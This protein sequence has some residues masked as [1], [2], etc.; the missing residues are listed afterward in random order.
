MEDKQAKIKTKEELIAA[1]LEYNPKADTA[2]IGKAYD[3]ADEALKGRLRLSG[4]PYFE[5]C[6]GTAEIM[7]NMK[8][9][10]TAIAAS[11]LHHL[12]S[13]GR[14]SNDKIRQ[15][16]GEEM[17]NLL[18]DI[19]KITDIGA[20]KK[21]ER[22]ENLRKIILATT[23]D[24]RVIL[25]KLA[26][27]LSN[28]RTLKYLPPDKQVII[29]QETMYI[30]AQIAHKLG[31][32]LIKTELQ[33]LAF[34][35]LQ[36]E[37]FNKIK[38]SIQ[39]KKLEREEEVSSAMKRII[40]ELGRYGIKAVVK[41]R[42]KSFYSI[43]NKM[44]AK[45]KTMD[46]I[47][48]LL[49]VRIIVE[50]I[51]VCY[52]VLG[53]VHKIYTPLPGE[54]DDYIANPKSN[55]YQSLHTVVMTKEGR[56][57]EVQIRTKK[58]DIDAE[59]GIAAHWRYKGVERD[60][61]FEK[62]IGWLREILEWTRDSRDADEFLDTLKVDLFKDEICVFTPKGDPITLPEG[63]TPIDF[64]YLVHT[65]IGERCS[66]AKVNSKLVGLDTKLQSGDVVEIIT[67]N[68]AKP[69]RNWLK[70]CKTN[71]ARAKIRHAL[72]ITADPKKDEEE[73]KQI[74]EQELV[75]MIDYDVKNLKVSKCCTIAIGDDITGI[76]TKDGKLSVHSSRC[77]NV[78]SLPQDRWVKLD[79][80]KK[81]EQ[82]E[83]LVVYIED[84]P[85]LL[86][87][88]LNMIA[89]Q[90][91]TLESVNTKARKTDT[92]CLFNIKV[93]NPERYKDF[94]EKLKKV[95]GVKAVE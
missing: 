54:F 6:L 85:G 17:L 30:Y 82:E 8:A 31:I 44:T 59:E 18:Q 93:N 19:S 13:E 45:N 29:A 48:D 32:N 22:A 83:H 26:D 24:T 69:S 43:Y 27:R 90:G 4:R 88:I 77:I 21:A 12:I 87:S 94:T 55:G 67:S 78:S 57:I 72:G 56:Q 15:E 1:V 20:D 80:I 73:L 11:L 89:R 52:T 79:W 7:V 38:R 37:E 3:F 25:I 76:K 95:E 51:E 14:A 68:S 5:H 40:G 84:R 53:I 16:F 39:E 81:K 35:Y 75:S 42:A 9:G 70:F 50:N 64:A 47:Y 10:S 66:K 61:L 60:A 91:I 49:A 36:P 46:E 58:M 71:A 23:K 41:G 2:L 33:D 92:Q 34:K 74:S 28:M 62:K 86:A 65:G 63:A